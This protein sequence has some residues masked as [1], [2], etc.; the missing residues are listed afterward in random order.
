MERSRAAQQALKRRFADFLRDDEDVR[1]QSDE[2]LARLCAAS[3]MRTADAQPPPVAQR[4]A[5]SSAVA[6]LPLLS[7]ESRRLVVDAE[8]LFDF[9]A[10]LALSCVP[11]RP[12]ARRLRG[13]A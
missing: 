3:I 1:P 6:M 12:A 11:Q 5:D 13:R 9:D 2:S 10:Q 8:A 4:N 7:G